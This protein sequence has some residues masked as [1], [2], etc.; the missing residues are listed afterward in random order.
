M[1]LDKMMRQIVPC[2]MRVDD[3]TGTWKLGQNKP[4]AARMA[5]ANKVASDGIGAELALLSQLMR[6][7]GPIG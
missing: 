4:D 5:A 6:D 3:I 2:R 7:G 1:V